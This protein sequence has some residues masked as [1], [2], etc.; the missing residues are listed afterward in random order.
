MTGDAQHVY[1]IKNSDINSKQQHKEDVFKHFSEKDPDKLNSNNNSISENCKTVLNNT[2][3]NSSHLHKKNKESHNQREAV[4][5]PQ[6]A[7][8]IDFKSLQNRPKFSGERTWSSSSGSNGKSS[9]QSPTGKNKGR[10]K[11]KKYGKGPPHLYKLNIVNS[12]SNPTIGIAYPQQKVTS[13][14][15]LE[16]N[17]EH[18]TGSYRFNVPS[19][20]EREAELQQEDLSYNR[21]FPEDSVNHTSKSYTSHTTVVTCQHQPLK[22]QSQVNSSVSR[23]S[24]NSSSQLLCPEFHGNRN[25]SNFSPFSVD[26]HCPDRAFPG[27]NYGMPTFKQSIFPVTVENNKP[28]TRGFRSIQFQYPIPQLQEAAA[29]PFSNEHNTQSHFQHDYLD[30]PVPNSQIAHGG[31]VFQLSTDNQKESLRNGQYDTSSDGRSCTQPSH[32]TKF[33]HSS[34]QGTQLQSPLSHYKGRND[35]PNDIN[36]IISSTDAVSSSIDTVPSAGAISTSTGAIS[37]ST[38]AIST[39]TGAIEQNQSTFQENQTICSSDTFSLHNNGVGFVSTNKRC[40]SLKDNRNTERLVTP[41]KTLR[42]NISHISL[43]QIH[44]QDKVYGGASNCSVPDGLGPFDK[45]ISNKIH[46]HPR[47]SQI[48]EGNKIFPT[49]DQSS[50][51]YTSSV[52]SQC[53]YPCQSV[54]NSSF[55][56]HR[57]H[58]P[59]NSASRFPWQQIHLT[60]VMPNQNRIELSRQ[61]SNQQLAFPPDSSEW[62]ECKKMQKNAPVCNSVNF[63]HKNH[64]HNEEL[65]NTRNHGGRQ[66]LNTASA[67]TFQNGLVN[68]NTSLC[69]SENANAFCGLNQPA[70]P[71]PTRGGNHTALS[72]PK[73]SLASASPYQSPPSSPALNPGS[74]STC[75]SLSPV[76]TVYSA[77]SPLNPNSEDGQLPN[78]ATLSNLYH[79]HHHIKDGNK[80]SS[81]EQISADLVQYDPLRAFTFSSANHS[82]GIKDNQMLYIQA[83][84]LSQQ[85]A[86]SNQC[87]SAFDTESQTFSEQHLFANSL[88]SANLDQLDV[89]LT[90]KQCD[91]NFSNV[92]SFLD[93]RQYCGLHSTCLTELHEIPRMVENRRFQAESTKTAALH[94]MR[95]GIDPHQPLHCLSKPCDLLLDSEAA[96]DPK[97]DPFKFNIFSGTGSSSISLTASDLEIDDAKL[98]SLIN[99]TLNGLDYQSDNAEIDSSFIEAFADDEFSTTKSTVNGSSFKTKDCV[100]LENKINTKSTETEDK[101]A[102]QMKVIHNNGITDRTIQRKERNKHPYRKSEE[103]DSVTVLSSQSYSKKLDK[104]RIKNFSHEASFDPSKYNKPDEKIGKSRGGRKL[105]AD[106]L[107]HRRIREALSQ[108]A[109][110][111]RK[112]PERNK[113]KGNSDNLATIRPTPFKVVPLNDNS[114]LCRSAVKDIK[115]RKS[116]S[117]TWSKELIQKIVQQKNKLHKLH[118][119]GNKKLQVPLIPERLIQPQHRSNLREY[120]YISDSDQETEPQSS[121]YPTPRLN[122]QAK[123]SIAKE[124]KSKCGQAKAEESWRYIKIRKTSECSIETEGHNQKKGYNGSRIKRRSSRAYTSSDCSNIT[125]SLSENTNSPNSVERSDSDSA[126]SE[127]DKNIVENEHPTLISSTDHTMQSNLNATVTC[128]NKAA[129]IA[130]DSLIND[131]A[132][133]RGTKKF[134]SAKF[135]LSGRRSQR[136]SQSMMQ[137]GYYNESHASQ[138]GEMENQNAIGSNTN[139]MELCY[140]ESRPQTGK[141]FEK[142]VG[143]TSTASVASNTELVD[144]RVMENFSSCE[145]I[146]EYPKASASQNSSIQITELTADMKDQLTDINKKM[147]STLGGSIV[148]YEP[149]TEC[150]CDK[151]SGFNIEDHTAENSMTT[152]YCGHKDLENQHHSN[153]FSE[154]LPGSSTHLEDIFFYQNESGDN[155][156]QK[157]HVKKYINAYSREKYQAKAKSP[158]PCSPAGI[159]GDITISS[160]DSQLYADTSLNKGNYYGFSCG[161]E[162]SRTDYNLQYPPLLEHKDW[163]LL[164]DMTTILPEEISH[165]ED[166]SVEAVENKSFPHTEG[167]SSTETLSL[168]P[169]RVNDQNNSFN[170]TLTDDDLEIKR[171]VTEL[172]N[173]LQTPK[174]SNDISVV[175]VNTE[176]YMNVNLKDQT[177][178]PTS[179][180]PEQGNGCQKNIYIPNNNFSSASSD[181]HTTE[182]CTDKIPNAPNSADHSTVGSVK[183]NEDIWTCSFQIVSLDAEPN[184]QTPDKVCEDPCSP[185]K[186]NQSCFPNGLKDSENA[187]ENKS[188]HSNLEESNVSSQRYSEKP[189]EKLESQQYTEN[190]IA[191]LAIISDSVL[192]NNSLVKSPNGEKGCHI[193]SKNENCSNYSRTDRDKSFQLPSRCVFSEHNVA[194]K[195]PEQ[196]HNKS[197]LTLDNTA[198]SSS[199]KDASGTEIDIS[200]VHVND[201]QEKLLINLN[202]QCTISNQLN[203]KTETSAL[204][205]ESEEAKLPLNITSPTNSSENSPLTKYKVRANS[206][207]NPS[208]IVKSST[209]QYVTAKKIVHVSQDSTENPLQQ[210]QLLVDRTVPCNEQ[211]MKVPCCPV[212]DTITNQ[213]SN[214]NNSSEQNEQ[215]FNST[216]DTQNAINAKDK[217]IH[218]QAV[219]NSEFQTLDTDTDTKNQDCLPSVLCVSEN[220]A[221]T[222]TEKVKENSNSQECAHSEVHS[223][224]TRQLLTLQIPGSQHLKK[225]PETNDDVDGKP[226]LTENKCSLL[227]REMVNENPAMTEGKQLSDDAYS[228]QNS[229]ESSVLLTFK[230]QAITEKITSAVLTSD[231]L[232][233]AA[234]GKQCVDI[235]QK[236]LQFNQ[237]NCPL[238]KSYTDQNDSDKNKLV[239][240]LPI[241]DIP[242]CK[243]TLG[244]TDSMKKSFQ[245]CTNETLPSIDNNLANFSRINHLPEVC[246]LM[247]SSEVDF[248]YSGRKNVSEQL[249]LSL[250]GNHTNIELLQ[251]NKREL[252]K[253]SINSKISFLPWNEK[254]RESLSLLHLP[255]NSEA[256]KEKSFHCIT[257]L[258]ENLIKHDFEYKPTEKQGHDDHSALKTASTGENISREIIQLSKRSEELPSTATTSDETAKDLDKSIAGKDNTSFAGKDTR[259]DNKFHEQTVSMLI[260][261]P[262]FV[263]SKSNDST[264]SEMLTESPT[265]NLACDVHL[266]INN[267]CTP[268]NDSSDL[269]ASEEHSKYSC[270]EIL[271]QQRSQS[272]ISFQGQMLEPPSSKNV[273][274]LN[275]NCSPLVGS[276]T[277]ESLSRHL[278]SNNGSNS[279]KRESGNDLSAKI[280]CHKGKKHLKHEETI[281]IYKDELLT[282]GIKQKEGNLFTDNEGMLINTEMLTEDNKCDCTTTDQQKHDIPRVTNNTKQLKDCSDGTAADQLLEIS[283]ELLGEVVKGSDVN[284]NQGLFNLSEESLQ[285]VMNILEMDENCEKDDLSRDDNVLSSFLLSKTR[286]D[287]SSS[288]HLDLA[289]NYSFPGNTSRTDSEKLDVLLPSAIENNSQTVLMCNVCSASFRSKQGLVRHKAIKH[290]LKDNALSQEKLSIVQSNC[291]P[292][293]D[294]NS[295]WKQNLKNV[296]LCTSQ[297]K[298]YTMDKDVS[299]TL[300]NSVHKESDIHIKGNSPTLASNKIVLHC[301]ENQHLTKAAV[302]LNEIHISSIKEENKPCMLQSSEHPNV[303]TCKENI[304]IEHLVKLP[305]KSKNN[306]GYS[307]KPY[308]ICTKNSTWQGQE[309]NCSILNLTKEK[310]SNI[311]IDDPGVSFKNNTCTD[312]VHPVEQSGQQNGTCEA[313]DNEN[314]PVLQLQVMTK[315]HDSSVIQERTE[316]ALSTSQT[317]KMCITSKEWIS[318]EKFSNNETI[319]VEEKEC[320]LISV[321]LKEKQYKKEWNGGFESQI[322]VT[323]KCSINKSTQNDS[324]IK[325]EPEAN[326]KEVNLLQKTTECQHSDQVIPSIF[327]S[328]APKQ[329]NTSPVTEMGQH[330]MDHASITGRSNNVNSFGEMQ[331]ITISKPWDE[332]HS[333]A[334]ELPVL[335]VIRPNSESECPSSMS[336]TISHVLPEGNRIVKKKCQRVYGKRNKKCK[337]D[338]ESDTFGMFS[339]NFM[340]QATGHVPVS[341][342]DD[343]HNVQRPDH[344][345]TISIN[346]AIMLHTSHKSKNVANECISVC[347]EFKRFK[348]ETHE[349]KSQDDL[350]NTEISENDSSN[351]MDLLYQS[352]IETASDAVLNSTIW[353]NPQQVIDLSTHGDITS[354]VVSTEKASDAQN[355]ISIIQSQQELSESLSSQM[356]EPYDSLNSDDCILK[357]LDT[358]GIQVLNQNYEIPDKHLFGSPEH[359]SSSSNVEETMSEETSQDTKLSKVRSEEGKTAKNRSDISI[360]SK[361]KQ[362]K[363]KVCFQWFLTLGELDFHKLSH[364]PSPPPTC[365]MCVQ[366]KFSSREQLRDHLKEKHA[367]NK[368]GIWTCGMCLKEIS[369]VWMYNEHLREHATQFARKGQAQ[370]SAIGFPSCF[371]EDSAMTSFFNTLLNKKHGKSTKTVN[372]VARSLVKETKV[373]KANQDQAW[374][375]KERNETSDKN[376]LNFTSALKL[377][378]SSNPE[379]MQ[380]TDATQKNISMHPDCK[381]PSR[382]CHHCGKQ[383]PKPFKLQRHLVVHSLQKIY[384]CYKCPIFYLENK[385]LRTHLKD[386]HKVIEEAEVKHTT[387]YTC[388]LCADVMHV[389]KKSF[390]C[391]TCNYTFSK[392]EQYDRHME[393]HLAGGSK[394]HKFRGVMRPHLP[395]QDEIQD[396]PAQSYASISSPPNKKQKV[397]HDG[398]TE[399]NAENSILT[400]PS[401][402]VE[403]S[404]CEGSENEPP[405]FLPDIVNDI[406]TEQN[407]L[408]PKHND[409]DSNFSEFLVQLEQSES[410]IASSPPC[411]SPAVSHP[412]SN[413][414]VDLD[415]PP[416]PDE[417]SHL[418]NMTSCMSSVNTCVFKPHLH[419]VQRDHMT[420]EK[421]KQNELYDSSKQTSD[422]QKMSCNNHITIAATDSAKQNSSNS[423]PSEK[424]VMDLE[425]K[426]SHKK[427]KEHKIGSIKSNSNCR[428]AADE[429]SRKRKQMRTDSMKKSD[430]PQDIIASRDETTGSHLISKAKPWTNSSQSKKNG[431]NFCPSRQLE[432]RSF[433]G[434]FRN[435]KELISKPLLYSKGGTQS[436][437][438]SIRKHRLMQSVKPTESHNYR[439]AESQSN[440]LSQLFGQKITSFKIPLRKDT[441]E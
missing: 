165:F 42:R 412:L 330:V 299:C 63:L 275:V 256:T 40:L 51:P 79:Q 386:E 162:D 185:P 196:D 154:C 364:N 77:N 33:V 18:V 298:I 301:K 206:S 87:S 179:L 337:I 67:F 400:I 424:Q 140:A 291:T 28:N 270:H 394:T 95:G 378:S 174:Q 326:E 153:I 241:D 78:V 421:T 263:Q 244:I 214:S 356:L 133:S 146:I 4:I 138:K 372:S 202:Q 384:L 247:Q 341:Y 109:Q 158:V 26:W 193:L 90:C 346:D 66:N 203:G 310:S 76:S 441:S 222:V 307:T 389:I 84:S 252:Q 201:S 284:G 23:D 52:A 188:R 407:D 304:E 354:F 404:F 344:Y 104:F 86:E 93:H 24:S 360:K 118:V 121:K 408:T 184:F 405:D 192:D 177:A 349:C 287:F 230:G 403:H 423:K 245:F 253:L 426:L 80:L 401:T 98:D 115:K 164:Q 240:H 172:E 73:L 45:N 325:I 178:L 411:L 72:M 68:S 114:R 288:E 31:F 257:E 94:S 335:E 418:Y 282:D 393:K 183:D 173:Q 210:L 294:V 289:A 373:P 363:C 88:S 434:E 113:H 439:T 3:L 147:K 107:L 431:I 21:R 303:L 143:M 233:S 237:P 150:F 268:S 175:Q 46:S 218:V 54:T 383:F 413:N 318:R 41:G 70:V 440:L 297:K 64:V 410:N 377:S 371:S 30:I 119:K 159:F 314:S 99:E 167:T 254:C 336:N 1:A 351:I 226:D 306:F 379:L 249:S 295:V 399:I 429:G 414:L 213:I 353:S 376:K 215:V 47:G 334:P 112:N 409:I 436:V 44:V 16:G 338:V 194:E 415:I 136:T 38:G 65:H 302:N 250:P 145:D 321:L 13:T 142:N 221:E 342:S 71:T 398:L 82:R 180:Q 261:L 370:K 279:A 100:P 27:T 91:Q 83:N 278:N 211:L 280:D 259:S 110:S 322:D 209:E 397:N 212:L 269:A 128:T 126:D 235:L 17:R 264:M 96:S 199:T 58:V 316:D 312:F 131:S 374:K 20:P 347:D 313:E 186:D 7:G 283:K 381:D 248:I 430:I 246:N 366:R 53:S 29:D 81:S 122:R 108:P 106:T 395:V 50:A 232:G 135:L 359:E 277:E 200:S 343:L 134:G 293:Q 101:Q 357:S 432:M 129:K 417:H 340:M 10:D 151:S 25:K 271:C 32:Q 62:Q 14:R 391:S 43:P 15:K 37:T 438:S 242:Q 69:E 243:P 2:C 60:S 274:D 305:T 362:Y 181:M 422:F 251:N 39:S 207:G 385:E 224:V 258:Q 427:R 189:E 266:E 437:S 382:D 348:G 433:N 239:K 190:L 308:S 59:K 219:S 56:D 157:N 317:I 327:D 309:Q 419:G 217:S 163:S 120:D 156:L 369:D 281:Q 273:Q 416:V 137:L 74:I 141:S 148:V 375:T 323:G 89:L 428:I 262:I 105:S 187:K 387:L 296:L 339:A 228:S 176:Q 223:M 315:S 19:I 92:A 55:A 358:D 103:N 238:T 85:N 355:Q 166:L 285:P 332:P 149:N 97:D 57:Q 368:A 124:H 191:S 396:S 182:Y 6:Q 320:N 380:Q 350:K 290:H 130:K 22:T 236:T 267:P 123:Y 402:H 198:S 8:K 328:L 152:I 35:H 311:E 255:C 324:H 329:V 216:H 102:V 406:A 127:K 171:L 276:F 36:G 229:D 272:A 144:Q 208:F 117:R 61:L 160:F 48:W 345:E 111:L 197:L 300:D 5:R 333:T 139:Q 34:T 225:I 231:I 125:S 292:K 367:K 161:T 420:H 260:H 75:S 352:K 49:K 9:P 286:T 195:N 205:S 234:N 425:A 392:K 155:Y 390:I 365:Y 331:N 204:L 132:H 170:A 220:I 227:A 361:E 435:K 11:S 12:R 168:L 319:I 388:E 116:G 265:S 169:E